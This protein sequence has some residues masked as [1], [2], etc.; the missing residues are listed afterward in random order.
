MSFSQ[1]VR[2]RPSRCHHQP[3][4]WFRF[5]PSSRGFLYSRNQ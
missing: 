4:R 2:S 1:A 3:G 5:N